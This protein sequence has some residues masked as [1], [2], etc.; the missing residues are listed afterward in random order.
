MFR[1]HFGLKFNPFD[2]DIPVDKLFESKDTDELES[3]LQYMLK[4]RGIFLLV[5]EPGSGKSTALR[6]LV[7]SLGQTLYR[8]FYLSLTTLTVKEFYQHLA[9]I[10][11]EIPANRKA[12]VFR[13]IQNSISSMY[14]DQRITPVIVIDEVHMASTAILDDMRLLCN[15]QMDSANP[16]VLILSGQPQIKNK[17]AL[18]TCYPLRQ[19]IQL[20]YTMKG[21]TVEE[22]EQYC[23]T[24]MKLAGC[25]HESV[26]APSAAGLIHSSSG[27]FLRTVNKIAVA[28]LMYCMQKNLLSVDKEVVYQANSEVEF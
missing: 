10:F 19:R 20:N 3:R 7:T 13:Q 16:F 27:G 25:P 5:G 6:K 18:N 4:N 8:T 23:N 1:Q 2:K 9:S 15:F 17:L 22:I 21:L 12:E 11:G 24:R 26:F 14:N 28:S